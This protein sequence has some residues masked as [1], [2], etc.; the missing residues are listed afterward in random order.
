MQQTH[1]VRSTGTKIARA[2]IWVF[3][4]F[5]AVITIFP[6]LYVVFG[7]FKENKELLVE[8]AEFLLTKETITGEEFMQILNE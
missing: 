7:S 4:L 1:E 8:I 6:V 5:I 3:L 2:L